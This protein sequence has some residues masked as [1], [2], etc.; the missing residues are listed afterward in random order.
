MT[1][2]EDVEKIARAINSSSVR[3]GQ[4]S[5]ESQKRFEAGQTIPDSLKNDLLKKLWATGVVDL[6]V[7]L[8]D[9]GVVRMDS[10]MWAEIDKY[11][12]PSLWGTQEVEVGFSLSFDRSS[13]D[14][15]GSG[16]ELKTSYVSKCITAGMRE[17]GKLRIDGEV[18]NGDMVEKVKKAILKQKGLPY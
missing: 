13:R 8:R 5:Q 11:E 17:D 16:W 14:S 18:V 10:N 6:F 12:K 2:K 15:I 3:Q 4:I 7:G 9:S 1:I